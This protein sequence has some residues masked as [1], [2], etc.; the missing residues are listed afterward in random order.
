MSIR[1]PKLFFIALNYKER[2]EMLRSYQ[3]EEA[4]FGKTNGGWGATKSF[5]LQKKHQIVEF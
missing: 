5:V 2:G 1:H 3:R 4:P